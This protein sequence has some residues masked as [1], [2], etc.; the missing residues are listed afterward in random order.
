MLGLGCREACRLCQ[1][2]LDSYIDN[3]RRRWPFPKEE[4]EEP[5]LGCWRTRSGLCAE[6]GGA[7]RERDPSRPS[8]LNPPS[9]R[10]ETSMC[11]RGTQG[12]EAELHLCPG[13]SCP[14]GGSGLYSAHS[15]L[16]VL[17]ERSEGQPGGKKL[18]TEK[19]LTFDPRGSLKGT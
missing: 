4:L 16:W 17:N 19:E 14:A 9:H 3:A 7:G 11:H 8:A 13:P 15:F 1:G 18:G 2:S 5:E 12:A 10:R 6:L